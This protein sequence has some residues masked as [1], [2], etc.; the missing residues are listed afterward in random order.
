[1][2]DDLVT[3]LTATGVLEVVLALTSLFS[4]ASGKRRPVP[5][6]MQ[7]DNLLFL[8]LFQYLFC[9]NKASDIFSAKQPGTK[10]RVPYTGVFTPC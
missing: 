8:E 6:F 5:A 3:Q 7:R 9:C 10:V 4:E 2:Q 1:V